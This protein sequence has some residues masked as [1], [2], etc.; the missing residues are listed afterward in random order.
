MQKSE[1]PL[2]TSSKR[3]SKPRSSQNF[4]AAK[5]LSLPFRASNFDWNR[6]RKSSAKTRHFFLRGILNRRGNHSINI[7]GA[8]LTFFSS[9]QR[10]KKLHEN[11]PLSSV[12]DRWCSSEE[13]SWTNDDFVTLN[14]NYS[15]L[16]VYF[17]ISAP[18]FLSFFN[19]KYSFL[20]RISSNSSFFF[21]RIFKIQF[22]KTKSC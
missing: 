19:S 14:L 20:K 7:S 16:P 15:S 5:T 8:L 22:L 9:H 10:W 2:A 3:I 1:K 4:S 13:T 21:S 12:R 18:L 11:S 6:K 17:C